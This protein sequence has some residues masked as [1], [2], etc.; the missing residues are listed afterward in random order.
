MERRK[1]R[2]EEEGIK[3]SICLGRK[4]GCGDKRIERKDK[5]KEKNDGGICV[6]LRRKG[7]KE[8]GKERRIRGKEKEGREGNKER[9]RKDDK[10]IEIEGI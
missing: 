3:V 2:K 4:E 6:E 9:G 10:E 8:G 7:Y 1:N 5:Q